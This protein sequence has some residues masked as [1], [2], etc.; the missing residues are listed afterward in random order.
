M[1]FP[2][3]L[4]DVAVFKIHPAIGVARLA[5]NDDE[6]EFFESERNR[7]NH[8]YMSLQHGRR[9]M[10]RQ[11]VQFRVFAYDENR[12]L[13]GE[14]T[15]EVRLRLGITATWRADVANRKLHNYTSRRNDS[16]PLPPISARGEATG[17][18]RTELVGRDPF[19]ASKSIVLGALSGDGR[20]SPP[21]GGVVR[22]REDD[23]IAP[24]PADES[25]GLD[26]TD[27]TSD[28]QITVELSNTN[29]IT[30]VPAWVVVAPQQHSPD[31][32]AAQL[33][34]HN[35][36]WRTVTKQALGITGEPPATTGHELDRVSVGTIN[37]DYNP[38]MEVS[39][40]GSRV[41]PA[42]QPQSNAFYPR[43]AGP[44]GPNEIRVQ[45]VGEGG[46]PGVEPGQL[47]SGLCSTW[48]GDLKACLNW[49]TAE[50]P[51]TVVRTDGAEVFLARERYAVN[52]QLS[53]PEAINKHA[54]HFG[55]A[56]D[57]DDDVDELRETERTADDDPA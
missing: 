50:F 21:R 19:D 7:A 53:D 20:F 22:R 3:D 40:G 55:V 41:E 51:N 25:R 24:F 2:D 27:S 47:T 17:A 44:I 52:E 33:D 26:V 57:L 5:N 48:Q 36:D 4:Q 30:V 35:K 9:T 12:A 54:D 43:D 46:A 56:R 10:M 16:E 39:L 23:T 38:G 31:V 6:Y 15:E 13:L 45:R 42:L 37:G 32:T 14:L 8:R 29:G 49:W 28:G 18:E 34:G 11:A 1:A